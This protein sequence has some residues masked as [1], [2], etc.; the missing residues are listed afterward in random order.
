MLTDPQTITV[1]AVAKVMPKVLTDGQ[2]AVYQ[3]ADLSFTLDIRHTSR[4]QNGK[5]RVKSLA[6]FTQRSVVT[7]PLTSVN[8][9]ETL[10]VSTQIDRPEAGFTSTQVQ[11]L[12]AGFQAWLTGSM[13]DKLYGRES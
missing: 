12:V 1:N 8:D 3:L 7:D 5:A 2:H 11:Q 6:T 4:K 9:F 10:V 13:A